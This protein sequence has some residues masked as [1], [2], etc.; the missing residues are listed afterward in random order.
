MF[1]EFA[2]FHIQRKKTGPNHRIKCF[3]LHY[4]VIFYFKNKSRSCIQEEKNAESEDDSFY[5]EGGSLTPKL[6]TPQ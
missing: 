3:M 4:K 2:G 6:L 1:G 5:P